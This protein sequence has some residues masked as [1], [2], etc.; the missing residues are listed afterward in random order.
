FSVKAGN[1]VALFFNDGTA[2]QLDPTTGQTISIS[3]NI[4]TFYNTTVGTIPACSQ[5][6]SSY[7]LISSNINSNAYWIWDGTILYSA[8]SLGP[9]VTITDGGNGYTSLPTVTTYG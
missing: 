2:L 8:G 1:F 6:G 4:D 9:I 7:L 3:S 5:Y